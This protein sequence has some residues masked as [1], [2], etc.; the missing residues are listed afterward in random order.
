MARLLAEMEVLVLDC[1]S[2][3][4][5]PD[6]GCLLEI[7]WMRASASSAQPAEASVVAAHLVALPE[8]ETIP[9]R[10]ARLTGVREEDLR[11]AVEPS[12]VWGRL[13]KDA[14]Q[15]ARRCR[16]RIAPAVIH[17][18]RFEEAFLRRLHESC[19]PQSDFP[20][21]ILCTHEIARRLFPELPRRGLR[22]LAGYFGFSVDP[23]RRSSGHV[24]A[25]LFVWS[26]LAEML[27]ERHGLTTLDGLRQWLERTPPAKP[28]TRRVYPMSRRRRL[29]LPEAPGVY[30]MLRSN[31]DLLYVG[32]ATSLR[33]R[34]NS[35]F[36]KQRRVAD[37]TLEMLTQARGIEATVTESAL[38][39]ALLESDEIKRHSPPYNVALR[40]EARQ[41]WFCSPQFD[42]I[43]TDRGDGRRIGPLTQAESAVAL[44]ELRTLLE[45]APPDSVPQGI[46]AR[47]LGMRQDL[48]PESDCF[49]EGLELF[50]TAHPRL[51]P[52]GGSLPSRLLALGKRLWRLRLEELAR[53]A[54]EGKEEK[55]AE[56][57]ESRQDGQAEEEPRWSA[58]RVARWLEFVVL[59]A[60]HAV[61]RAEW[62]CLL[63]EASLAWGRRQPPQRRRLLIFERGRIVERGYL[64]AGDPL[65]APPGFRRPR[66]QRQEGFDLAS[67]DRL[68]VLTTELRRLVPDCESLEIRLGP[69]RMLDRKALIEALQWI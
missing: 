31:G 45:G 25:T 19:D 23:L 51:R 29:A 53:Q 11:K 17:F 63:S 5:N 7:G 52:K 55:E 57:V 43:S 39:A 10:V 69:E 21:D 8:G 61:R 26:R 40:Q 37:R 46:P 44:A 48:A 3:G 15:T 20:L 56:S 27:Q 58:E 64:E 6:R 47:T 18:A 24:A 13:C 33:K 22:A 28:G 2:T 50:R 30:R 66:R 54:E 35:Y 68:R 38:E 14:Q 67:Y 41:L 1:Q 32:K 59:Q 4:A 60:A 65:P 49:L 62:L 16:R 12:W 9:A 34:V 36:Q 42:R